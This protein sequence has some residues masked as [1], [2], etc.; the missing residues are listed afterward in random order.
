M[1]SRVQQFCT[2][3]GQRLNV[4][5]TV[6]ADVGPVVLAP[7][8]TMPHRPHIY[9]NPATAANTPTVAMH[10]AHVPAIHP[11]A[12]AGGGATATEGGGDGGVDNREYARC[13]RCDLGGVRV[14]SGR[15]LCR[16]CER[17]WEGEGR[18]AD[19]GYAHPQPE[20]SAQPQPPAGS[21]LMPAPNI[22]VPRPPNRPPPRPASGARDCGSTPEHTG[23]SAGSKCEQNSRSCDNGAQ[24][25][26]PHSRSRSRRE[27]SR[28]GDG[29]GRRSRGGS[30]GGRDG[31]RAQPH[32]SGS[33]D[34][35]RN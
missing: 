20:P 30:R 8:P 18:L 15:C 11:A 29:G 28:G 26:R 9:A 32:H 1:H 12:S 17:A 24:R 27:G 10:A 16:P 22:L 34:G 7:A 25:E 2:N 23:G 4:D 31:A 3:C 5:V 33:R 14:R 21:V 6:T 35:R 13:Q 19:W